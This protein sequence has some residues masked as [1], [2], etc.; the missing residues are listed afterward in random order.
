MS[1]LHGLCQ[2]LAVNSKL[3]ARLGVPQ[4]R[5]DRGRKAGFVL[6]EGIES[7]SPFC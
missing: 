4:G 2:V 3:C 7:E 1:L 6:L 5:A